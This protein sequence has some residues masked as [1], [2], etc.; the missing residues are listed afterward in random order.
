MQRFLEMGFASPIAAM[1]AFLE[2]YRPWIESAVGCP[3]A[4]TLTLE[5][6]FPFSHLVAEELMAGV[7]LDR[8]CLGAAGTVR[9]LVRRWELPP[10]VSPRMELHASRNRQAPV[11]ERRLAWD[12]HWKETPIALWLHE[13]D[14]AIVSV[15]IP[16]VSQMEKGALSWRQWVIVNRHEAAASLNLLRQVEPPRRISVIGGRDIPLPENWYD[17][18]SVLLAPPLTELVR[19]DFEAF[20]ESEAWFAEHGLPYRRGYL[21][22]GP[23]GNGKTSVVRIMAC[24]PL[25]SAFSIDFSNEGLPNDALSDLFQAAEDKAPAIIILEDLDRVFGGDGTANRSSIT[26]PHLLTCLDGLAVQSGIVVVATAND[27][28]T[29]DPAI[30]KRP[31]RFDRLAVFPVPSLE[32]RSEYLH[33]LT[34]GAVDG[35]Q[36]A[37]AATS[38]AHMS[39]AQIREAYVLAGQRSF[40]RGT[41]VQANEI[42]EAIR[43]VRGEA[44][45]TAVSADG[46]SVGF[47]P[48]SAPGVLGFGSFTSNG[49]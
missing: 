47:G 9:K 29:L 35:Q 18:D 14:H 38:A 4:E 10:G 33:R 36:L 23:P 20:W 31:G 28:R 3:R 42:L 13:S 39:F 26:L 17:W 8:Q 43:I 30:I 6:E 1:E 49:A 48:Q 25:V 11:T 5:F 37:L 7:E 32:L 41:Q 21:L 16:Y 19:D 46:R 44:N 22:F 45:G 12:P 24:H 40:R 34:S 2:P 15:I 27:P